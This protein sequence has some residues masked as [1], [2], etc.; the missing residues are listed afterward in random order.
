MHISV[1]NRYREHRY[2]Y[3]GRGTPLGNPFVMLDKSK[4]QRDTA[5]DQYEE[6]FYTVVREADF[7]SLAEACRA[8]PDSATYMTEQEIMLIGIF[9][10]AKTDSVNLGCYCAPKRCHCDTIKHFLDNKLEELEK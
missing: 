5:C 10:Q 1:V 9:E 6:W 2:I 7:L 4:R 3:C 8:D